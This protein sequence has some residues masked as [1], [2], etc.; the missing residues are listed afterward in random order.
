MAAA[1]PLYVLLAALL[2]NRIGSR[3][4]TGRLP[5]MKALSGEYGISRDGLVTTTISKGPSSPTVGAGSPGRRTL[6]PRDA[7][8]WLARS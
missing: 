1:E 7:W 4:L 8:A 3:E 6:T 2:R 5:S